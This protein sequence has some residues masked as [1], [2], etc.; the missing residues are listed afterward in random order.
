MMRLLR[1]LHSPL[2]PCVLGGVEAPSPTLPD[3]LASIQKQAE[4]RVTNLL[5]MPARGSAPRP[6]WPGP[7]VAVPEGRPRA[8]GMSGRSLLQLGS[9]S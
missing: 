1:A 2:P 5:S 7:E 3:R 9:A 6:P 8:C 4:L